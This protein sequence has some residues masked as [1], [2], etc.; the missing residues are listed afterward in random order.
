MGVGIAGETWLAILLHYKNYKKREFH[1][2]RNALLQLSSGGDSRETGVTEE[3][4]GVIRNY[5]RIAA[6]NLS[7]HNHFHGDPVAAG[8]ASEP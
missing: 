1:L 2:C 6:R 8:M 4:S 3:M 5:R 7:C